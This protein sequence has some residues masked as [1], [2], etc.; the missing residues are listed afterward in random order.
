MSTGQIDTLERF[1]KVD[2]CN[3]DTKHPEPHTL[4]QAPGACFSPSF[5]LTNP[6][7]NFQNVPCGLLSGL[8]TPQPDAGYRKVYVRLP[9]PVGCQ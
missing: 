5:K 6:I 9:E 2:S 1:L 8:R 7:I 4:V 3:V